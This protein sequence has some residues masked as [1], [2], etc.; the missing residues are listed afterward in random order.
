MLGELFLW[1]IEQDRD[2]GAWE[3]MSTMFIRLHH[4]Q[5]QPPDRI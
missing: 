2:N 5:G 3:N 4:L 1:T